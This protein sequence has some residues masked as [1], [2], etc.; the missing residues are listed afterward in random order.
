MPLASDPLVLPFVGSLLVTGG[1][2][3]Y[4]ARRPVRGAPTFAL[5]MLL[6]SVWTLCYAL[7]L[8]SGTLAGKS[9]WLAAKYLGAAPAPVAWFVF[10]L[11]MTDHCRWLTRPVWAALAAWVTLTWGLVFTN[12][13]HHAMWTRIWLVPGL[14][15]TQAEHGPFFGVYAAASYGFILASVLLYFQHYRMTPG[16]FR[17]QAFWLVLGGFLPL[18]GRIPEDLF[19][20]DLIPK[21]DNVIFLFLFSGLLFAVALFRYSALTLVPIAHNLVVH[22]LGAGIIVLD[23]WDRVVD[24]NPYAQV[25]FHLAPAT[26][27]GQPLDAVLG[28]W[29]GLAAPPGVE[30]E[31]TVP[32]GAGSAHL[33]VQSSEI[34]ERSGA[35][36]GRVIVL[37]DI[38]ERKHAERQLEHLARTDVLTGV[39]NRRYFFELAAQEYA[40][41]RRY[42]SWLAILL[43]DVDHF[44]QIN[45]TYGHQ[46]GDQVL[47]H[48][49]AVCRRELRSID[50]FAR[51][52]GEEFI[53]LLEES[54]LAGARGTAERLRQRI[55]EAPVAIAGQPI[56]V[57]ISLGLVHEVPGAGLAL[58]S[59]I[60]RADAAL[61]RA[62]SGG[63]NRVS[64]WAPAGRHPGSPAE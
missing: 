43:L 56:R 37:Y 20:I 3:A 26:A 64:V 46:A 59:L 19:G 40:R 51:Y 10:S 6:L 23:P 44:K 18:G 60:Q 50:L 14:P 4:A 33:S 15:E 41:A 11:H 62:K 38:T 25:L 48:V 45:D 13:L 21:L 63:R 49:A 5:L 53:A 35:R 22:N 55:A 12:P 8:V 9:F 17:R 54:S 1:L 27:I 2:A 52:G 16:F 24:L 57:T 36:A 58:E 34:R 47:Q 30:Q 42:G 7:E 61:Y 28:A 31:I 29:P 39:T 32:R